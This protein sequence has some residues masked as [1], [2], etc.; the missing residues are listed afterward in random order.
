MQ[1]R[2]ATLQQQ[3]SS[4]VNQ[5]GENVNVNDLKEKVKSMENEEEKVLRRLYLLIK[6]MKG[7]VQ[8][9]CLSRV[10]DVIIQNNTICINEDN[11]E[12]L[13]PFSNENIVKL[14]QEFITLLCVCSQLICS[15]ISLS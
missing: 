13:S 9:D 5:Q 15:R 1:S 3:Q 6:Q 11:V 7:S 10:L 8:S 4:E 14:L 12:K 2:L